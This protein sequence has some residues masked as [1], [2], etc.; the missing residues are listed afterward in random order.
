ME[1]DH[2]T[3]LTFVNMDKLTI[4]QLKQ[5]ASETPRT[6][7]IDVQ[8]QK[9]VVK[10]TKSGKPY[11]EFTL[12]DATDQFTLKIWENLPQFRS[13]QELPEN[14][15]LRLSGDWT[16]NQYGIDGVRWDLRPMNQSEI[17]SFLSGDPE[18][19]FT[20]DSDWKE[21]LR[22]T[23]SISDPRLRTLCQLF[24]E[25]HGEQFRR[26]AAA[27]KNHHARRGGLVEH[28][29]QMMRCACAI[30][31]VYSSLNRDLLV[32]GI[33]FHDCGKL[34]ENT[35]PE[36]GFTQPY[37]LEGEMLGHIPLGIN[38]AAQLWSEMMEDDK[39]K[40]WDNLYPLSDEVRIH[41]LHL[42][43]SHHG[44]Y[45][46]GSPALPRT[47]EA[48]ALHHIDNLDAKYEMFKQAYAVAP[49]IAPGIHEKQFPLPANLVA[50][51]AHFPRTHTL[52]EGNSEPVVE[53]TKPEQEDILPPK[54]DEPVAVSEESDVSEDEEDDEEIPRAPFNGDLLF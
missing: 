30:T 52:A 35:Y 49:E 33:L 29:A 38:L 3:A 42:I 1:V 46:F 31:S 50:P 27:R 22:L 12:A 39:A 13:A 18:T 40:D 41:L 11:L 9:T 8:V 7:S 26:T 19:R 28:V 53:E 23:K 25:R 44:T 2:L 47:P 6:A 15:F 51:L 20:Q 21:I 37:D 54:K 36:T 43:A 34:W 10:T 4:S 32:A 17:D 5:E 24:I 45:E 16:Q 48:I 14:A